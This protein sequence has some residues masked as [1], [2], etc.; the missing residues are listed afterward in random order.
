LKKPEDALKMEY[1]FDI[2]RETYL[3]VVRLMAKEY[4]TKAVLER[5]LKKITP[6]TNE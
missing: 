2:A 6:I 1:D 3:A 5:I 4:L